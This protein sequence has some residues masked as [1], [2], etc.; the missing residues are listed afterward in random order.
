MK[1][2]FKRY[3]HW[4]WL[5]LAALMTLYMDAFVARDLLD[6]DASEVLCRAWQMAQE[7]S[8][9]VRDWYLTTEVRLLD[10]SFVLSLFFYVLDDWM[11]VRILGTAVMQGMYVLS[12]LYLCR[13]G[14]VN[15]KTAVYAAGMLML[16]ISMPYAR[17]VLYHLYYLLYMTNCFLMLGLTL[18][19][20]RRGRMPV[21]PACLLGLLWLHS[22]L[23]GVR[24][25][26]I[27]GVPM[28]LASAILLLQKLKKYRVENS[29][30]I[31]P[32][33]LVKLEEV[34]LV[35][36]L[37]ASCCIFMAG[38]LI[39]KLVLMPYYGVVDMSHA[40][41][42]ASE[43]DVEP[44]LRRWMTIFNGWQNAIGVRSSERPLIGLRGVSLAASLFSFGYLL[45]AS[46]RSCR[47]EGE[48]LNRRLMSGLFFLGFV[49]TTLIFLLDTSTSRCYSLYYVPVVALAFLA[50]AQE[51]DKLRHAASS[52][53]RR[54]MAGLVCFCL[55]FQGAYSVYYLTVERWY[56]DD[57]TGSIYLETDT[58]QQAKECV[59]FLQENGYDC[60][61]A[62]YWDASAIRE[63]SNGEITVIP[64]AEGDLMNPKPYRWGTQK[65]ICR[66]E[67][68]PESFVYFFPSQYAETFERENPHLE[69]VFHNGQRVG[70]L[71][72]PEELDF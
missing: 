52:L 58:A 23:N 53:A 34:R 50:L 21:L 35:G 42:S 38:F 24:H 46:L 4:I 47:E 10:I 66:K 16:P 45:W 51:M 57:W 41:Y 43:T 32:E 55:I 15:R 60:A 17:N 33:P 72:T 36:V 11:L 5:A 70:Y 27:F 49:S 28:L 18:R 30:I 37:F 48:N 59:A 56:L 61:A 14:G 64:V 7:R 2:L 62:Y 68:M 67:N 22:G 69:Q 29:R 71:L 19:V 20:A 6:G 13:Q 9:F 54:L 40:F 44:Y 3:G 26:M 1:R 65:S 25:M 63:V 8:W 12:F 39:N 31:G